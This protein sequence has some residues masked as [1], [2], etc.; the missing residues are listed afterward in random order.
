MTVS[1][2]V[3]STPTAWTSASIGK[4]SQRQ[5]VLLA[6]DP[7]GQLMALCE[8][9]RNLPVLWVITVYYPDAPRRWNVVGGSEVAMAFA[10]TK[11]ASPPETRVADAPPAGPFLVH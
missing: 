9:D 11:L 7:S 5:T 3:A 8:S 4:K 2:P 10:E 6:S 1:V